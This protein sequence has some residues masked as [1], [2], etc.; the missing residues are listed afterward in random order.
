MTATFKR[1]K[2]YG[3]LTNLLK[4]LQLKPRIQNVYKSV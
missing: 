2:Q 3:L 4:I 1:F